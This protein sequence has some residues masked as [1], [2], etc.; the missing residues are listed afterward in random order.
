M[1]RLNRLKKS[2]MLTETTQ[3][4]WV[5]YM[6][7]QDWLYAMDRNNEALECFTDMKFTGNISK[8]TKAVEQLW[9]AQ[10]MI[11]SELRPNE[12]NEEINKIVKERYNSKC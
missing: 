10:L 1:V 8:L 11:L 4:E 5:I 7:A 3:N 9:L 2:R 12:Y 6:T